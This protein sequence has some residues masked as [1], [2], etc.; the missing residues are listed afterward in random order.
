MSE[1]RMRAEAYVRL[2]VD[3]SQQFPDATRRL[4]IARLERD[5]TASVPMLADGGMGL[6]KR[7][8]FRGTHGTLWFPENGIG[9]GVGARLY[10]R[11]LRLCRRNTADLY[12]AYL[13]LLVRCRAQDWDHTDHARGG[14]RNGCMSDRAARAR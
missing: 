12:Q 4:D 6:R 7:P 13:R 11:H 3:L 2:D 10:R 5:R 1:S 14:G 9:Q 8:P